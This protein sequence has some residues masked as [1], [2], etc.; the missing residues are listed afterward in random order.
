MSHTIIWC[1]PSSQL[2]FALF[3]YVFQLLNQENNN[4]NQQK[5]EGGIQQHF[6]SGRSVGADDGKNK[7]FLSLSA[8]FNASSWAFFSF[9]LTSVIS[10][11]IGDT[12]AG[13]PHDNGGERKEQH[14]RT[15]HT[16]VKILG[17]FLLE[18]DR[19]V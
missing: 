1:Y 18:K 14:I 16:Q 4:Q 9:S 10:L 11:T 3:F 15:I 13:L 7:P 2:S 19:G 5:K 17:I 8:N 12:A 6:A